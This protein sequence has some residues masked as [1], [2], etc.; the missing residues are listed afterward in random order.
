[1]ENPEDL[2]N[3]AHYQDG[4]N[5]AMQGYT[6]LGGCGIEQGFY[7]NI[8]CIFVWSAWHGVEF[9]WIRE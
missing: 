1:M 3:Q 8:M 2:E 5:A 7:A 9:K 6:I 4:S